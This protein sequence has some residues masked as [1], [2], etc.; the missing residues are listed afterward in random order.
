MLNRALLL[1][2]DGVVNVDHG[3]VVERER[4]VFVDGIFELARHAVDRGFRVVIVTN[5]SGIA[6]GYYTEAAFL[7]LSEW[8]RAAFREHGVELAGL[9]HCPYHPKGP[10]ARYTRDSFWRKPNPGM[11]LDAARRLDLDLSRSVFLGDQATDM[12]AALT[13][14]VGLRVQLS[15]AQDGDQAASLT[16]SRLTDLIPRLR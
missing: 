6:R 9:F 4:F 5:Q 14:G 12:Q 15:D 2:R 16:I 11:I 13:A 8:M 7:E 3:Y 1:D 10:V